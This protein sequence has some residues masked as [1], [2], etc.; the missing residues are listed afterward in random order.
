MLLRWNLGRG[1]AV[2]PKS[3]SPA[4]IAENAGVFGWDLPSTDAQS[5]DRLL[6]LYGGHGG[7]NGAKTPAS[8]RY[9]PLN[10]AL[11]LHR[12]DAAGFWD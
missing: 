6:L 7:A 10:P 12:G 4:H 2:V 5:L 3:T 1:V 9:V 8:V 11:L